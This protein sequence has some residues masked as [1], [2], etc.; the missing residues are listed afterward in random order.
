MQGKPVSVNNGIFVHLNVHTEYSLIDGV[1]RVK[2]L[3]EQ[4]RINHMPA[5]AMTD[6]SN[7]YA[8]IKFYRACLTLG[9]KPILGLEVAVRQK[10]GNGPSGQLILLCRN[11]QGY[12][13]LSESLTNA[14]TGERASQEIVFDC[15]EFRRGGSDLIAISGGLES[16][17]AKLLKTGRQQ[18]AEALVAEYQRVFP[19]GYY[20]EVTRTGRLGEEEN[21]AEALRLAAQTHTPVVAT[22][23]TR[24]LHREDFEAH[25]IRTCINEGRVLDDPR[26]PRR[27]TEQQ[28][29]RTPREMC[30][31]FCDLPGAIQN[32]VEIAKRCNVFLDFDS[33]HM[34][35]FQLAPEVAAE[36]FLDRESAAGLKRLLVSGA[37][38]LAAVDR[39]QER[40]AREIKTIAGMGFSD[41]FLIVADFVRW[42]QENGIPV[43]PGR[44]S[45]AG[46][47]VAY[48]LGITQLDPIKYGL[49]FERFLNPERVSLPDFDI[50]FCMIGRDRVIEYV[51]EKYGREKVA[52]I[53]TYNTLA[54]RAVVRDVG[55]VMGQPYGFCDTLAKLIPFEVG[56]TLEKALVQDDELCRRYR[57]EADVTQLI[58][59]A[60]RLEGMPR[61]AGKHAGG[62]VIAPSAISDFSPLYWEPG[63]GQAVTQFDK[64]DLEA[65]GLVKFD[66]LGLRTLTVIDWA[67]AAVNEYRRQ[68]GEEPVQLGQLALDD[69]KVYRLIC[70]G[71]T[72][73][74]FQLESRGMQELIKRLQPDRFEELI[75]LVALFRPGPL[76]S[77]MV[78]DF[79]NRKHGRESIQYLHPSLEKV[80]EPTHGV[81]LYQ[82]QVMEIAQLLSG[83]TLGAADLLRRAM[84][85][86]KPE[87]MDRQRRGFVEGAVKRDIDES[88]ASYIF[89]LIEKFA[90]YGF[91]KSHSAAYALLSYQTAWLKCHYPAQFMAAAL[92]ADMDHTDKVVVLVMECRSMGLQVEAPDI[93]RCGYQFRVSSPGAIGYGLG[94]IKG[95]GE[96]AIENI[97]A[98]REQNGLFEDLHS[99][100]RRVDSQRVNK[101]ALEALIFSGA[102]DS[103]EANRATLLQC[104]PEAMNAAG[105]H[106]NNVASGQD[107]MFG[108]QASSPGKDRKDR[109]QPWSEKKKLETERMSLGF[110]L[111]GH[112]VEHHREELEQITSGSIASLRPLPERTV[113][114]AGLVLGLR[115]LVNQRGD[116]IAFCQ[117]DDPSGR[118]DISIFSQLYGSARAALN[119]EGVVLVRGTSGTDERTGNLQVKA[120][121][122]VTLA[123]A[124][125]RLLHRM[126]IE[127]DGRREI[128]SQVTALQGALERYRPG[129]TEIAIRYLND[130]GDE[131]CMALG[132][133]WKVEPESELIEH[134][135]ELFGHDAVNLVFVGNSAE[136]TALHR[137]TQ[138]A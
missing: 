13:F 18:E 11:N 4:A 78:D 86:K 126:S 116:T 47:L 80:L 43:G 72:T 83:Y 41:Y 87:E 63:M 104:L 89:D 75:A 69:A 96:K 7:M 92:S 46:S 97:L 91:N 113:T 95:I 135:Y 74:L 22:N 52:Q 14:Y 88:V 55:R 61:N 56:M 114:V 33:T 16:D 24:F 99:L 62:L 90:G 23:S 3:A 9:V 26:R 67:L 71:H 19:K 81:I 103:L 133:P 132:S 119:S 17:V 8:T 101:K 66:F 64:D 40:L 57:E 51:A 68:Q 106:V 122:V 6:V 5:V 128:A 134:L 98:E 2:D 105:Q 82:E 27:F 50:D 44:G 25:E 42:A 28:Y 85:K 77:G 35:E 130:V 112:P 1:V 121:Q 29:L 123:E 58:D 138:A 60:S 31:L 38:E 137:R 93:N 108:L 15:S 30:E 127:L 12:R 102:L 79:I 136:A 39:Y 111:T 100:C 117:L 109:V 10:G 73:A 115:S 36:T 94:A 54:A 110:Y 53:I 65:I 34:P 129:P 32:S 118:A 59:N 37:I 48:A 76:Q 20:L 21:N 124:R 107:D 120:E 131:V 70:T 125:R 84:G 45:G 49:L